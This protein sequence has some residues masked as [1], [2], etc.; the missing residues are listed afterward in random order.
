MRKNF[1]G[2]TIITPDDSIPDYLSMNDIDPLDCNVLID[3]DDEAGYFAEILG[4]ENFFVEG[5]IFLDDLRKVLTEA[6]FTDL[7]DCNY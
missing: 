2:E 7:A 4:P 1:F 3:Y 6:G 5:F